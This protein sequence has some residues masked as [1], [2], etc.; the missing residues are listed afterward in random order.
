MNRY[1]TL[2]QSG[3]R[4]NCG[5]EG[6]RLASSWPSLPQLHDHK[7]CLEHPRIHRARPGAMGC[8][9]DVVHQFESHLRVVQPATVQRAFRGE[10]SRG[11]GQRD[12]AFPGCTGGEE[13]LDCASDS[14]IA[15]GS[16]GSTHG[17]A[18]GENELPN[19]VGAARYQPAEINNAE[20]PR[21]DTLYENS[22]SR[23]TKLAQRNL[24]S[25]RSQ[26]RRAARG[27]RWSDYVEKQGFRGSIRCDHANHR[28]GRIAG[29]RASLAKIGCRRKL[30]RRLS[31]DQGCQQQNGGQ[32]QELASCSELHL[33]S[34]SHS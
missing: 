28:G 24:V 1:R 26:H 34:L 23:L 9:I 20:C 32:Y 18:V 14:V 2:T 31:L 27:A 8:A 12:L 16:G 6:P 33:I 13:V 11:R 10:R 25:I 7:N 21:I 4:H 5:K 22:P 19:A 29:R 3:H 17:A 30:N 15:Y